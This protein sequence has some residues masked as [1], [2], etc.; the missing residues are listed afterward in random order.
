MS[1]MIEKLTYFETEIILDKT[2]T[3]EE[4]LSLRKNLFVILQTKIFSSLKESHLINN[5][6]NFLEV[7]I[8]YSSK[9]LD[10]AYMESNE[11]LDAFIN[12]CQDVISSEHLISKVVV[13]SS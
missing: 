11:F 8:K 1:V 2:A 6:D 3:A 5:E 12:S 9:N 10:D 4:L 7:F 13:G